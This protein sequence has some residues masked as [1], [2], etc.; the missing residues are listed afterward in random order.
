MAKYTR[1]SALASARALAS[2]EYRP[3]RLLDEASR[4]LGARNDS[5]LARAVGVTVPQMCR[6]RKRV[7][8]M[9]PVFILAI[10]DAVPDMT[11]AEARGLAGLPN[12]R[13]P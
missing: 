1:E 13:K 8:V 12:W 11:A 6:V 4:R 7:D 9:S 3:G 2:A 5:Q 10:L